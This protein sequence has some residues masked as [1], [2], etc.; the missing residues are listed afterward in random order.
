[1]IKIKITLS[2]DHTRY[3][4]NNA[5]KSKLFHKILTKEIDETQYDKVKPEPFWFSLLYTFIEEFRKYVLSE[6]PNA[7]K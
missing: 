2:I 7:F 4:G 5:V 1:M 3:N 6:L